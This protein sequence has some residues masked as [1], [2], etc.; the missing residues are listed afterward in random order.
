MI[1][2]SH[3]VCAITNS[4]TDIGCSGKVE[5]YQCDG[6][7]QWKYNC[8]SRS[9]VQPMSTDNIHPQ[10]HNHPDDMGG[11]SGNDFGQNEPLKP[12]EAVEQ[13]RKVLELVP[14]S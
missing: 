8:R 1:V 14:A 4:F 3:C 7:K 6:Q 10:S 9:Q 12:H 13:I 11:T 5:W 2:K